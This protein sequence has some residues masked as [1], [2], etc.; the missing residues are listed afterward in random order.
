MTGKSNRLPRICRGSLSAR[1]LLLRLGWIPY[2]PL[3]LASLQSWYCP[4]GGGNSVSVAAPR[5]HAYCGEVLDAERVPDELSPRRMG[6]TIRQYSPTQY[7][8]Q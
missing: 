5:R 8:D 6:W 2:H 3:R 1:A 4:E 7:C